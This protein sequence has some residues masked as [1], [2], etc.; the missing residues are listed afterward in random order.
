MRR[1]AMNLNDVCSCKIFFVRRNLDRDLLTSD[2]AIDI[3]RLL[4]ILVPASA[5]VGHVAKL[6]TKKPKSTERANGLI[7]GCNLLISNAIATKATISANPGIL[8]GIFLVIV[9]LNSNFLIPPA[10]NR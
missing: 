8:L 9:I 7:A 2:R 4:A 6:E 1:W 3:T 5:Q 10:L